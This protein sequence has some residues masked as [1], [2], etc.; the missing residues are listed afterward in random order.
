MRS[1]VSFYD[2]LDA[3]VDY[4]DLEPLI[5]EEEEELEVITSNVEN[6]ASEIAVILEEFWNRFLN[7]GGTIVQSIVILLFT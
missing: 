5:E 7:S 6:A 4:Y 1:K 2:I 3:P